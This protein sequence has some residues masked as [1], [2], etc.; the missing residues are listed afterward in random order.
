M[1]R[2]LSFVLFQV[3]KRTPEGKLYVLNEGNR[4]C[5]VYT[6]NVIHHHKE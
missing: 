3:M 5:T 1:D 6:V 2:S 4:Y